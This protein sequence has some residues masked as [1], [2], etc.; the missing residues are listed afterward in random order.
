[1]SLLWNLIDS[2]ILTPMRTMKAAQFEELTP[3][4]GA[5]VFLGDSIT[6]GGLWHE[7][8]PKMVVINRGI[9]GDTTGGVLKRLPSAVT[10]TTER[11]VVLIG[12]NDLT[13][14][15]KSEEICENLTQILQRIRMTAP[16]AQI[17]V[18]SVMPRKAKFRDRIVSLN[19][20]Y[21]QLADQAGAIFVDLWPVLATADGTL[22]KALTLDDLHL[23]GAGYRAWVSALR[24]L[25]ENRPE[26]PH[27]I[28]A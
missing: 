27:V 28:S 13:M 4:A 2:R 14:G 15:T 20:R 9:D 26:T 3:P 6:E 10:A 17:I 18:Q 5:T 22:R 25:L 23:N 21:E 1:M 8:F 7:W 24:P 16:G 11:V 12:T 19:S